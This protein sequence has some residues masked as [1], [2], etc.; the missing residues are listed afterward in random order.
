M[1]D[2]QM[3]S[4]HKIIY[5]HS[6]YSF[7]KISPM[8][9]TNGHRVV[10]AQVGTVPA[11][12]DVPRGLG[13]TEEKALVSNFPVGP[14]TRSAIGIFNLIFGE[15]LFMKTIIIDPPGHST[16]TAKNWTLFH[17]WFSYVLPSP[18]SK[19]K[20][21]KPGVINY[22]LVQTHSTAKNDHHFHLKFGLLFCWDALTEAQTDDM[23]ENSGSINVCLCRSCDTGRGD[24]WW[25]LSCVSYLC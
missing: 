22:P 1:I 12:V 4:T 16:V 11:L 2:Q 15:K 8:F 23:C 10:E 13:L 21:N 3:Y 5:F 19:I 18:L 25:P 7:S 9:P 14:D 24:H 20:R 17:M 6:T